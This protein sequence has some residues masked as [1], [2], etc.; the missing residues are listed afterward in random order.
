MR[1]LTYLLYK[2][3]RKE[4]LSDA[5]MIARG[6]LI[7]NSVLDKNMNSK[8]VAEIHFSTLSASTCHPLFT[9]R[10]PLKR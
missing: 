10:R 7:F 1:V 9:F 8:Q 5:W 4:D 6:I 3:R 2:V